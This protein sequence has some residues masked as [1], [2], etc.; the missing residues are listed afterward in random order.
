MNKKSKRYARFLVIAV[1]IIMFGLAAE[2]NIIMD[3]RR[4][5]QNNI[6][7][8]YNKCEK[9]KHQVSFRKSYTVKCRNKD[10]SR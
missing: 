2:I 3:I 5:E 8:K 6:K 7:S 9:V 10:L 1:V 4:A